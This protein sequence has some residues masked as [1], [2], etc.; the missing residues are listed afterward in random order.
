MSHTCCPSSAIVN[1]NPQVDINFLKMIWFNLLSSA[2]RTL[3]F[4]ADSGPDAFG[5][6]CSC[7]ARFS[8]LAIWNFKFS[9][10]NSC[11]GTWNPKKK[12]LNKNK[13]IRSLEIFGNY[14]VDF[15]ILSF[16][17]SLSQFQKRYTNPN[18]NPVKPP[19][20]DRMV[21]KFLKVR[22]L[23]FRHQCRESE[24]F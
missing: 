17:P 3:I 16:R 4:R 2:S 24:F 15:G 7:I 14:Q 10:K 11:S 21:E 6:Y 12:S 22:N 1:S 18:R 19:L 20:F 5:K 13:K 9:T 8:G 23:R